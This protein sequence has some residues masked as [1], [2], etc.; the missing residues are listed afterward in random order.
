[1]P[2]PLHHEILQFFTSSEECAEFC[3]LL[4]FEKPLKMLNPAELTQTKNNLYNRIGLV[5][6][7]YSSMHLVLTRTKIGLPFRGIYERTLLIVCNK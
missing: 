4:H 3:E 1:M 6:L 7:R 5:R 2:K